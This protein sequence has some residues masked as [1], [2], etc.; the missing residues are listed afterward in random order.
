VLFAGTDALRAA[1]KP[2][3]ESL[4]AC[5][6]RSGWVFTAFVLFLT[7][8]QRPPPWVLRAAATLRAVLP[9]PPDSHACA[10]LDRAAWLVAFA[11]ARTLGSPQVPSVMRQVDAE[12]AQSRTSL[13]VFR[14]G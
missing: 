11:G 2:Q 7:V 4:A 12:H 1:R 3:D 13:R 6:G 5:A 9:R 8:S 14:I 10:R